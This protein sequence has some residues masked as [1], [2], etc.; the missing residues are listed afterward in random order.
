MLLP[1][2]VGIDFLK[3]KKL[4]LFNVNAKLVGFAKEMCR[5]IHR[6]TQS[7]N[8]NDYPCRCGG[9]CEKDFGF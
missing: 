8:I 5:Y 6:Q 3:T 1:D 2:I 9:K 4:R 7:T